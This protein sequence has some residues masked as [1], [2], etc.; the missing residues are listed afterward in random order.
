M[1]PHI[2]AHRRLA[3][4]N[5]KKPLVLS[6]VSGKGVKEVLTAIARDVAKGKAGEAAAADG[7]EEKRPWRP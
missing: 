1:T 7:G 3:Q 5:F 6:A 2:P 4:T